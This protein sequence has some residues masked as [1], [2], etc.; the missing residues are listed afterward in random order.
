MK[1]LNQLIQE[2]QHLARLLNDTREFEFSPP[3]SEAEIQGLEQ[4]LQVSLP[5]DYKNFLRFSN[6]ARLNHFTAELYSVS[7]IISFSDMKKAD[8]FPA[9]Y[10]MLADII[11]DGEVLCFSKE[12]GKFIRCFDG[13]EEKFETFTDFLENMIDFIKEITE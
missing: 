11:G 2:L 12:T 13:E 4:H 6:G 1:E 3:A 8:W 7:E 9:D 10:V 5:E